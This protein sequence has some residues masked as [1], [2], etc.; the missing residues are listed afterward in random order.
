MIDKTV[1][2][3]LLCELLDGVDGK[4]FREFNN[5]DELNQYLQSPEDLDIDMVQS[6][7]IVSGILLDQRDRPI[8]A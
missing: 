2:M 7:K 3:Y 8:D 4:F 6:M 1:K 5:L